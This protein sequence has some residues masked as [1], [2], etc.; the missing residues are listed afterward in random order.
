MGK[1]LE[2]AEKCKKADTTGIYGLLLV[3]IAHE[4]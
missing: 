3:Q 4:V 1:L 2:L